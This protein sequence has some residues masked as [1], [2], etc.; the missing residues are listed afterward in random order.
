MELERDT[1]KSLI[2]YL[3]EHG[4]PQN[5]IAVE[6]QIGE[7]YRV[8]IAV[9]DPTTNV[10]IQLFE[11]KSRKNYDNIE[12]GKEQLK[13]FLS[14]LK[15]KYIPIY[16]VF[17]K[18]AEPFFEVERVDVT[19]QDKTSEQEK[20]AAFIVDY[21]SQ[22]NARIAEEVV[23][24]NKDKN[25]TVDALKI[26]CWISAAIIFLT[27]ILAKIKIITL[28]GNDMVAFGAIVIL[29]LIPFASKLK[30]LGLEFERLTDKE[31]KKN[32]A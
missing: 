8:D 6:Y 10:P 28:D 9:I 20:K 17:P 3:L 32:E 29:I 31:N 12:F 2:N 4:Y 18:S 5:S 27:E 14:Q 26:T 21:K 16:L 7:S 1:S 30:I 15:N 22:R 24:V 11:I 23:I 19:T 13:K 25:T